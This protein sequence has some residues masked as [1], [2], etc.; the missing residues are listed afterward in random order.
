MIPTMRIL[1]ILLIFITL[2]CQQ[3]A[4]QAE[5]VSADSLLEKSEFSLPDAP[6]EITEPQVSVDLDKIKARGKLVAL[7]GYSSNS[8]FIYKGQ[9][10]GFEY[11]L[12]QE[13]AEHLEVELEVVIVRDLD[14]IFSMLNEGRGDILAYSMTITKERQKKVLFTDHHTL[15]RQVLVQKR[16]DNWLAL[17]KHEIDRMLITDAVELIGKPVHVRK[18]SS[19]YPRL[20]NLSEE[21]GGDID[22]VEVPGDVSTDEL[23]ADVANGEISY[24]VA[25]EN[26]AMI[27][28]GYHRN[29]HIETPVS[30]SQRIA[31]A[32]RQNSPALREEI[33]KWLKT[34]KAEPTYNV[35]Y[36]KYYRNSRFYSQRVESE[37][38][39]VVGDKISQY[40]DLIKT[41]ADSLGWDWRLLASQI[42]QESEFD[43]KA[44]SWVGAQGLMQ[45]MP[46]T[47]RQFGAK[48][49]DSPEDNI[50]TGTKYLSWLWRYWEA[51]PDSSERLKFVLASYN[52]G[53][54]HV[55]DARRLA[56]KFKKDPDLW[57]ENVAVY[58]L[59]KAQRKYFNDDVVQFGYCRGEEPV[60]YVIEILER[61]K[62]YQTLVVAGR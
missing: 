46:G 38:F 48:N 51:I 9:P 15:I 12:L 54:G 35:L 2:S 47:A 5:A 6:P 1:Y 33:N 23:I 30:F 60:N 13:L 40:D 28:A 55:G 3:S 14:R 19:Y 31:W 26:V 18:G 56:E 34:V 10:L 50:K 4:D 59:K 37:F 21:I 7:T 58:M 44:R 41:Y 27:N 32:V 45:L 16:P 25:D 52:A 11:E 42:F 29:I 53:Q 22:I 43:P 57:D 17:K 8:Y 49:V 20:L 61:Y 36:R 39:T 62:H 24:T